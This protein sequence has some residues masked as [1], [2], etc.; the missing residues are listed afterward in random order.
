MTHLET[1]NQA[2]PALAHCSLLHPNSKQMHPSHPFLMFDGSPDVYECF[3]FRS[4]LRVLALW[5]TA[6][7]V[8]VTVIAVP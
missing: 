8:R 3:N 5:A 4:N 1:R 2:L 7:M 6:S